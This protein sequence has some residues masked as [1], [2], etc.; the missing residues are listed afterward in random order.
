MIRIP[1]PGDDNALLLTPRWDYLSP[2]VQTLLL[3]TLLLFPL[4][5]ALRLYRRELR[6]VP[7]R[8]AGLLL[9]LRILLL[10][11]LWLVVAWQ[12]SLVHDTAEEVHGRV[13]VAVDES[14]S[15]DVA[16]PQ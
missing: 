13:I 4:A 16:D 1:L 6:F 7:R 12:P 9:G 2:A 11:V 8:M 5:L 15:M 10:T 3:A 14:R